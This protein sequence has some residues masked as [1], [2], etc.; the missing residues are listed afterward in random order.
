MPTALSETLMPKV[1]NSLRN[2]RSLAKL[3]TPLKNQM[4]TI[5]EEDLSQSKEEMKLGAPFL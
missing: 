1:S 3:P 4:K 2:S 5:N